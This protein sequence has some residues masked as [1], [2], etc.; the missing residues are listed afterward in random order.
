MNADSSLSSGSLMKTALVQF[1]DVIIS[2]C[3]SMEYLS[4]YF[5]PF[6]FGSWTTIPTLSFQLGIFIILRNSFFHSEQL[7]LGTVK[8]SSL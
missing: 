8:N 4:K 7:F 6:F 3:L 2:L 1:G 5:N